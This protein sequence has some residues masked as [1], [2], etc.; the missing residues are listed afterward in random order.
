MATEGN[1]GSENYAQ[2][3]DEVKRAKTQKIRNQMSHLMNTSEEYGAPF[4]SIDV[5]TLKTFAK[6]NGDFD[7]NLQE[8]FLIPRFEN[9]TSREEQIKS[10]SVRKRINF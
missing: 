5:T 1:H 6:V 3:E 4:R 10:K 9:K 8:E 2:K 7:K